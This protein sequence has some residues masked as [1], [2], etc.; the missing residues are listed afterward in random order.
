MTE[1]STDTLVNGSEQDERAEKI[2]PQTSK[3][4]ESHVHR[5]Q[6][7][8]LTSLTR[9]T[10][11]QKL[12]RCQKQDIHFIHQSHPKV[13]LGELTVETLK[14]N[15]NPSFISFTVISRVEGK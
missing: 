9:L 4:G 8:G 14:T 12:S 3:R 11:V 5:T 10:S 15:K 1:E 13:H 7:Q 6:I 2:R